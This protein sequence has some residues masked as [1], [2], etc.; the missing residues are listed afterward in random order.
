MSWPRHG[1]SRTPLAN[2]R[3]P[4][5]RAADETIWAATGICTKGMLTCRQPERVCFGAI[6]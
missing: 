5:S 6:H 1:E 3:L 4:K 2:H